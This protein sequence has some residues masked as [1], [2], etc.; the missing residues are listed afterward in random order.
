[1]DGKS[2]EN[3]ILPP[4][5]SYEPVE[6]YGLVERILSTSVPARLDPQFRES[7][8]GM[9]AADLR[10]VSV[11]AGADARS[12]CRQLGAEALTIG[13][14]I[15]VADGM[16]DISTVHGRYLLA[17]ELVHVVQNQRARRLAMRSLPVLSSS[18]AAAELEA[19]RLAKRMLA[20]ESVD[21]RMP[22]AA[23]MQ[24]VFSAA[25]K[26]AALM[27]TLGAARKPL[28]RYIETFGGADSLFAFHQQ[29]GAA[30]L[31]TLGQHYFPDLLL[32]LKNSLTVA[33]LQQLAGLS[34]VTLTGLR[35]V[36][37]D[38]QKKMLRVLRDTMPNATA[39]TPPPNGA[40]LVPAATA[41]VP[42]H[43]ELTAQHMNLI[44]TVV[45]ERNND[46]AASRNLIFNVLGVCVA[47]VNFANHGG[48]AV[49]GHLH[50]YPVWAMPITGHHISGVPH[51][52]MADYPVLWR[53]MPPNVVVARA[54][55]T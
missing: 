42:A 5:G 17:H 55:G 30:A 21:V 18:Q 52:A 53:A 51:F 19:D 38:W 1:M 3:G 15:I 9:L 47:E 27:A 33:D 20:G 49:S 4:P 45:T 28:A 35:D 46:G 39:I 14:D 11:Y 44:N 48:T 43:I 16:P 13:S 36:S 22:P 6:W 29:I 32:N 23:I 10:A 25:Q 40:V 24:R 41:G 34:L 26:Q 2:Q 12:L 37:I 7:M 8:E 31:T 50:V 54:L